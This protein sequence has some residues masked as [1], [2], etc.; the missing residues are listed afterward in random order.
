MYNCSSGSR[1]VCNYESKTIINLKW[2]VRWYWLRFFMI[3][4]DINRNV[5]IEMLQIAQ[6]STFNPFKS[7]NWLYEIKIRSRSPIKTK[8]WASFTICFSYFMELHSSNSILDSLGWILKSF[9][10]HFMH[11][12]LSILAVTGNI[13]SVVWASVTGKTMA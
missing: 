3:S 11:K 4:V 6:C 2:E 9:R 12:C 10:N 1:L 7:S 8:R 13:M 5:Q